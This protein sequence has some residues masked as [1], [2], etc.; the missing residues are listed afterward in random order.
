MAQQFRILHKIKQDPTTFVG[1][2][3]FEVIPDGEIDDSTLLTDTTITLYCYDSVENQAVF[4]KTPSAIDLTQAPFF[5]QAQFE[6]AT[7]IITVP[8]ETFLQLSTMLDPPTNPT[9]MLYSVGRCGSTLLSQVFDAI[10]QTVSLSEPDI[11]SNFLLMRGV[12]GRHDQDLIPLLRAALC[13]QLKPL[14]HRQANQ[15]CIKFRSAGVEIADLLNQTGLPLN[16][17]FLYRNLTDQTRSAIRAFDLKSMGKRKLKGEMLTRWQTLVPLLANYRWRAR[18]IG[19]D[20]V[21]L[22][23]LA[24]LSRMDQYLT[25]HTQSKS[26]FAIRYEDMIAQPE[27]LI[28]TLF[29]RLNI[30]LSHVQKTLHVFNKDSQEGSKLARNKVGHDKGQA[31]SKDQQKQISRFLNAHPIINSPAFELPNTL[32]S[33]PIEPLVEG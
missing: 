5:Y 2:E 6:H 19:L 31:L 27:A 9:L 21:D 22:N 7:A 33:S 1:I 14:P 17:I 28:A 30:P 23:I 13:F 4:V 20:R 16:N 11:F 26:L 15:W 10:P 32:L 29:E 24:W 8:K 12:N 25:L 3:D 18:W